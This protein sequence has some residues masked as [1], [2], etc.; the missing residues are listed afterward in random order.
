MVT[1][2]GVIVVRR[3]RWVVRSLA[4]AVL[5]GPVSAVAGQRL[6]AEAGRDFLGWL[7]FGLGVGLLTLVH[8]VGPG[9]QG[10]PAEV[11][12]VPRILGVLGV[13]EVV[14]YHTQ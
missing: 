14:L 4:T 11:R 13:V 12:K 8:P 7:Q 2:C 9:E 1:V 10:R 6:S 3:G 5:S